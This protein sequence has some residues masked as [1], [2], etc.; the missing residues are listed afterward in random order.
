ML[1]NQFLLG[2]IKENGH[3]SC[4]VW[5]YRC[6]DTIFLNSA[7]RSMVLACVHF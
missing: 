2:R 3:N 5:A 6:L 7:F 4:R 1:K